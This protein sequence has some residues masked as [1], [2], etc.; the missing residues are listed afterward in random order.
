MLAL[1][2]ISALLTG[3]AAILDK[4]FPEVTTPMVRKLIV[5]I[6]ISITF[7]LFLIGVSITI[8][9]RFV[10]MK[11]E[12]DKEIDKLEAKIT[13]LEHTIAIMSVIRD[14]KPINPVDSIKKD[15]GINKQIVIPSNGGVTK[16]GR[17]HKNKMLI[18]PKVRNSIQSMDYLTEDTDLADERQSETS[19]KQRGLNL[20]EKEAI[21]SELSKIVIAY[22]DGNL[23]IPVVIKTD[24]NV[25]AYSKDLLIFLKSKGYNKAEIYEMASM[26]MEGSDKMYQVG[27]SSE[28]GRLPVI[29][30]YRLV[31]KLGK[32]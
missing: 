29:E 16:M 19:N 27:A 21:A 8:N 7:V 2:I 25:T 32:G 5:T 17:T 23:S 6:F 13:Q 24:P 30:M 28:A 12:K 20:D 11:E 22:H 26:Q 1:S 9:S 15:I 3:F 10:E 31:K 4:I 18:S 14:Q